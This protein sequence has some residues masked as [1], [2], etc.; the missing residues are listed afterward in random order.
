MQSIEQLLYLQGVGHQYTGYN[1]ELVTI[2]DEVRRCVLTACGYDLD[3][4]TS[5]SQANFQLDIAPWFKII[6]QTSFVNNTDGFF[7]IRVNEAQLNSK[8]SWQI[9]Q[10]SN[11]VSANTVDVSTLLEAGNYH[12]N[13][14]CFYE[15]VL[16]I[17]DLKIGYYQ[18]NITIDD[19][20]ES[21]ELIIYPEK[22][23][24]SVP[25]QIWGVS[26]QLYSLRGNDNYG[27]GDFNDLKQIVTYSSAQGA[28]YIL[29]NPLHALFDDEPNRASPYSPS[30]RLCL[31]PLYIH[32]QDIPD[33]KHCTE[34]KTL[35]ESHLSS[36]TL[37]THKDDIYINYELIASYKYQVF[38]LLF[39]HFLKLHS[40]SDSNYFKLFTDFKSKH[41]ESVKSYG[42]WVSS[43]QGLH[44]QYQN[45]EFILYLQWQ[46]HLQFEQCQQYA[47]QCEMKVGLI[48]DLAVGCAQ[49]GNEFQQNESLF[50][51]DASIGAPPDPWALEGQNWGLPPL[52]P[53]KLKQSGFK[54]YIKLLQSNMKYCGALRIDHIMAILRL[55]WC[56]L[57]NK[58]QNNG[59]YVYYPF[60]Q[61]LALLKLESHLNQCAV[62][63]EDLGVVPIEIKS[64]LQSSDIYSNLLFYFEKDHLGEFVPPCELK[65]HAMIMLANHDV[66]TFKAWWHKSDINLRNDLKLFDI[67]E[68]R[69]EA[70]AQRDS[71]K[72]KLINWLTQYSSQTNITEFNL[73]T[74]HQDIYQSILIVLA[75]SKIKLVTI[76]LDDLDDNELPANIPGTD[77]VYP[78]W[79]RRLSN[80]P[81]ELF[82][83]SDFFRYLNQARNSND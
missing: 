70:I 54:H 8:A 49:D 56:L 11:L 1:A 7:K 80:L 81:S 72:L 44:K 30:D 57:D 68:D 23:Y 69:F 18:I 43:L 34:A 4:N 31:N 9:Y 64:A 39:N 60:Q 83:E 27:I 26:L 12:Y 37:K 21:G 78:N 35:L 2:S 5:I 55:W 51:K 45:P 29:V 14:E 33:F 13:D 76:Q 22:A 20:Q 32:I 47:K 40:L 42:D 41:Q 46:A 59:C 63:G 61:L 58:Q 16:K 71:D 82:S 53:I 73:E 17:T 66:P 67:P 52:E 28:D 74:S 62:I 38:Y 19:I 25:T 24:Q 6:N 3:D 50:I 65:E 15:L 77:K 79:R 10:N 75:N 36:S 48:R